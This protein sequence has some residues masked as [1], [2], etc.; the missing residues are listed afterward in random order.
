MRRFVVLFALV[1]PLGCEGDDGGSADRPDAHTTDAKLSD[2]RP[3]SPDSPPSIDGAPDGAPIVDASEPPD[4]SIIDAPPP[5]DSD[6]CHVA[7]SYALGDIPA[8]V[9]E[10]VVLPQSNG[11]PIYVFQV[12]MGSNPSDPVARIELFAGYGVFDPLVHTGTFTIEGAETNY[13][14]CGA[15]ILVLADLSAGGDPQLAY[16]AQSGTLTVTE[17]EPDRFVA[18]LANIVLA[19]IDADGRP[20][21]G[22]CT[23]AISGASWAE[24]Y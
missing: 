7:A 10:A 14:D 16:L 6:S 17:F 20:R 18:S 13:Q 5:P 1:G 2:A 3:P 4:A 11:D 8:G 19:E 15:C 22:G 24:P 12:P 23:T 9:G 21:A